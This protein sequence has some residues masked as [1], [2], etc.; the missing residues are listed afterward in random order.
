LCAHSFDVAIDKGT[1]DAIMS[2]AEWQ[3]SGP[4]M[5]AEVHRVLRP[6]GQWLLCR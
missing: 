4:A 2:A 1:L 3:R 6:G 5:G